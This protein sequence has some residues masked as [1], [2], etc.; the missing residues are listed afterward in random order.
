M[1][2]FNLPIATGFAL[3]SLTWVEAREVTYGDELRQGS[4]VGRMVE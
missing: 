3:D 2:I 1:S 4:N